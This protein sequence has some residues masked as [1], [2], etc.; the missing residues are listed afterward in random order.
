MAATLLV[1]STSRALAA[2]CDNPLVN[3]CFNSDNYWP[4]PGPVRFATVAGTET[5]ARGQV[6]FGLITSYQ[7]R[8]VILNLASPGGSN[9]NRQNVVDNQ[10]TGN[11]LFAY[12]VTDRLELDFALPVTFIQS[13]A[14]VSP[15]TG[16]DRVADTAV[17]DLR[18]GA[19]YALVPRERASVEST[20]ASHRRGRSWSLSARFT[21]S[22]PTGDRG[23]FAGETSAVYVPSLAAD[24]RVQ[25]FFFGAEL[26]A[27]IRPVT[28]FAGARIGTQLAVGLGAGY[29]ILNRE[30]LAVTAEARGYVNLAEQAD[31]TQT[32]LGAL[33][34]KENGKTIV[35]A[36]WFVGLRSAPVLGGDIA[37]FGGGGGPIPFGEDAI[38]TPRFRFLLGIVYAPLNRDSDGDGVPDRIDRCVNVPGVRGGEHPGCPDSPLD[39]TPPTPSPSPSSADRP[40]T[41]P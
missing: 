17:R 40:R 29:D 32:A 21:M 6:G 14:G 10:V 11:F 3:T 28:E 35:P 24:Y 33:Q 1:G 27:R 34:S 8:P 12:G 4:T 36:E 9:G 41:L 18:F 38:T 37:F 26:G 20:N 15:L 23:Q 39:A 2:D 22:A 25:R 13:G 30:R 16:G 7:S 5:V 31:T 19:A